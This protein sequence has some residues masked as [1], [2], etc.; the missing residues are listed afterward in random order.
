[1]DKLV[2]I[3]GNA[4]LHR[5]FHALPPL[6]N[7]R[8]EPINAVYGLVSML[9]K[10]ITD[11]N[12]THLAVAFDRPEPTFRHKAFAGYQ[13]QRPHLADELSS[14]FEKA[15][16]VINAFG[17]PVYEKAGFEADDV[18]GTLARL[19]TEIPNSKFQ[20]PN[21][22]V[23]VT[24]DRDQLQLV[25]D[26]VKV[27]LPIVG[28][29]NAKLMGEAEVIEKMGVAPK[30]IDD[31]KAL[32]GDPSDNYS[33]VSGIGPKT[34]ISLLSKYKSMKGIYEHL[35]EIPAATREKLKKGRKEGE[36]S[37]KLATIVKDVPLTVKIEDCARWDIDS[38][39]VLDVFA[40]YGFKTLTERV[41][42]VGKQLDEEKQIRLI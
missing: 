27:Y 17:I 30:M 2:L 16:R 10:V 36:L 11:L 26:K 9:L 42:K 3:D 41:K 8:G 24:G 22:V 1:M 20:I 40:E 34:A 5:A 35:D 28:L 18:I 12:P 33:G 31:Y 19:A 15:K 7:R 29:A 38:Q 6:T 21:E 4:I 23:I 32:V 13:A 37:K 14:Q 39:K 25:N